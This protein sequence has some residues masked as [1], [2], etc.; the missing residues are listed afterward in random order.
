MADYGKVDSLSLVFVDNCELHIQQAAMTNNSDSNKSANPYFKRLNLTTLSQKP[1]YNS[2]SST[3][4]AAQPNKTLTNLASKLNALAD[5]SLTDFDRDIQCLWNDPPIDNR[6]NLQMVDRSLR[7]LKANAVEMVSEGM[8]R[9]LDIS[10]SPEAFIIFSETFSEFFL[11]SVSIIHDYSSGVKRM[12]LEDGV[13]DARVWEVRRQMERRIDVYR[14]QFVDSLEAPSQ[15]AEKDRDKGGRP[16]ESNW[17]DMEAYALAQFP[18]GIPKAHGMKAKI[19]E[20]MEHWLIIEERTPPSLR[21]LQRRASQI[22]N[23]Y[24]SLRK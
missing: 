23:N 8:K 14:A 16:P 17:E 9:C 10:M 22:Y 24:H 15:P 19:R 13:S 6:D 18:I 12:G 5:A 7:L 2:G 4:V 21:Q 11:D 20:F 3:Q 1:V